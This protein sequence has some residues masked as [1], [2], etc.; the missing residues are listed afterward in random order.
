MKNKSVIKTINI[1]VPI[2]ILGLI[3]FNSTIEALVLAVFY[4]IY[5]III[6]LS[7]IYSYIAI[8][9][10]VK[11]NLKKARKYYKKA[12]EVKVKEPPIV[13]SYAYLLILLGE[14]DQAE[15][16]L[17][18]LESIKPVGK[19]ATSLM[20]CNAVLIWKRDKNLIAA[21][22]HVES[23]DETMRNQWYYNVYAKLCI[24]SG[25]IGKAKEAALKGYEYLESNPVA[26]ENLLIVHCIN[27]EYDKALS[28][29]NKLIS[30]NKK[31]RASSQ[32]AYFYSALAYEKNGDKEMAKKLYIKTLQYE[33]TTMT[34]AD[35]QKV[36]EKA[37]EYM[38]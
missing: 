33:N 6:G 12:Y 17:Q 2:F 11:G 36:L 32:D 25:N 27:E 9:Y 34:Y 15:Q 16:V 20:L 28:A 38:K 35:K 18:V 30:S 31:F 5:R 29:A 19:A 3:I 7:K 8:K 13:A 22:A 37:G 4:F 14:Y 10:Y 26:V 23:M 24:F 21:L 1:I